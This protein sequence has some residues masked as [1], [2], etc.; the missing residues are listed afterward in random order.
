MLYTSSHHPP[1]TQSHTAL[2]LAVYR[3]KKERSPRYYFFRIFWNQFSNLFVCS[4]FFSQ[5]ERNSHLWKAKMIIITFSNAVNDTH[6][7]S[8]RFS[9]SG[10]SYIS[11]LSILCFDNSPYPDFLVW[12]HDFSLPYLVW[13]SHVKWG[14]CLFFFLQKSSHFFFTPFH[15][16]KTT[17]KKKIL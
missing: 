15:S 4:C 12:F 8:F 13:K 17:T 1:S 7:H 16:C 5:S 3:R 9:L 10:L 14:L 2:Q 6:P 11:I